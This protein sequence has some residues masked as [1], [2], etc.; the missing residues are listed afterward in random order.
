MGALYDIA[1]TAALAWRRSD[2]WGPEQLAMEQR[3]CWGTAAGWAGAPRVALALPGP[4]ATL[5]RERASL[6]AAAD[7]TADVR[8]LRLPV[9][10]ARALHRGLWAP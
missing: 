8:T 2:G 1:D 7:V 5:R 10:L 9:P 6:M 4:L 3:G